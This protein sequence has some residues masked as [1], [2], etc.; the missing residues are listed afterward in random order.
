MNFN[1]DALRHV[2]DQENLTED[3]LQVIVMCL[4][5]YVAKIELDNIFLLLTEFLSFNRRYRNTLRRHT[6]YYSWHQKVSETSDHIFGK[7]YRVTKNQFN[8]LALKI[9]ERVG[10]KAFK[11]ERFNRNVSLSG[12][13]TIAIGIRLL[14]GGSYLDFVGVGSGFNIKS[15]NVIYI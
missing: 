8:N 4:L 7:K 11:S 1:N 13:K 2:L 12:E 15:I 3:D 9:E 14:S 6:D 10:M 5:L